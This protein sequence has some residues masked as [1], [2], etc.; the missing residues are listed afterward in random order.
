M[1]NKSLWK[2]SSP[3]LSRSSARAIIIPDSKSSSL[4]FDDQDLWE[5]VKSDEAKSVS[6]MDSS[7]FETVETCQQHITMMIKYEMTI[8]MWT[9]KTKKTR[10]LII[11]TISLSIMIYVEGMKDSAEMWAIL[12]SRYK[13]KI[14]VTLHQLQRQFNMI[15]MIDDD[16][17]MKKHFQKIK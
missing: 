1:V 6:S 4:I 16:D 9:K 17:D 11:S 7:T 14:H 8:I 13:S 3:I 10:K 5:V 2:N 12:E 15:K